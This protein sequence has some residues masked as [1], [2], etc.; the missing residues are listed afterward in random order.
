MNWSLVTHTGKK[1]SKALQSLDR[2]PAKCG[3]GLKKTSKIIFIFIFYIQSIKITLLDEFFN[4][5]FVIISTT[6]RH[7]F[8]SLGLCSVSFISLCGRHELDEFFGRGFG[9]EKAVKSNI[10]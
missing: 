6:F 10:M 4:Q 8:P 7:L 9:M 3:A 2:K 1:P 5:I